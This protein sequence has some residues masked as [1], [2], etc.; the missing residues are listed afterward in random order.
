[1]SHK[2]EVAEPAAIMVEC[3]ERELEAVEGAETTRGDVW[4]PE[5]VTVSADEV[6]PQA[7]LMLTNYIRLPVS[8]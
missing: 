2:R 3:Q 4:C 5:W 7:H 1:M 8:L 6:D